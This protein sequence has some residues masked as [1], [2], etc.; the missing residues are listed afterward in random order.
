[1]AIDPARQ[2]QDDD[3]RH[4]ITAARGVK[5]SAR[6]LVIR[7]RGRGARTSSSTP[8]SAYP[9][10]IKRAPK[11]KR[12]AEPELITLEDPDVL[13]LHSSHGVR[14]RTHG[15]QETPAHHQGLPASAP[16]RPPMTPRLLLAPPPGQLSP[17]DPGVPA[18][19][20]ALPTPS[21]VQHRP[22]VLH[23]KPDPRQWQTSS[24]PYQQ[25]TCQSSTR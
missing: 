9:I 2:G 16:H 11:A 10:L 4:L 25:G 13:I 7:Q 18:S 8:R 12:A 24:P 19:V 17:T 21:M 23:I 6:Q 1:M 3:I 14:Q 5:A 22:S 20:V 15:S